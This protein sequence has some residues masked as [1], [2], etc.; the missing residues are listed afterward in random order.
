MSFLFGPRLNT[1]ETFQISAHSCGKRFVPEIQCIFP[2]IDLSDGLIAI[3]TMQH[4]KYDL[5]NFD[6]DVDQE[7]DVLLEKVHYYNHLNSFLL[8][9]FPYL[10]RSFL[11]LQSNSV[12]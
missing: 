2:S 8:F 7:K 1:N 3:V 4:S 10:V 6:P 9:H 12:R 11:R 5:V